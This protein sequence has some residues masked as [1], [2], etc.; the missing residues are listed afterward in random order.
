VHAPKAQFALK[1]MTLK[2][3]IPRYCR[4]EIYKVNAKGREGTLGYRAPH[5]NLT[6]LIN[7]TP[8]C[9]SIRMRLSFL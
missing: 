7:Q 2:T 3:T 5:L 9:R 4:G 6:G 8:T 1:R